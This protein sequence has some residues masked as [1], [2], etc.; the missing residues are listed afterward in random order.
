MT[1]VAQRTR[2]A[3]AARVPRLPAAARAARQQRLVPRSR[4]A[5]RVA[6]PRAGLCG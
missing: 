6:G 4:A 1:C 2:P 5:P 3:H